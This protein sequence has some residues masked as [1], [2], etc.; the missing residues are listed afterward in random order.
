[1]PGTAGKTSLNKLFILFLFIYSFLFIHSSAFSAEAT[2]SRKR[3]HDHWEIIFVGENRI[4]YSNTTID[5]LALNHSIQ[6]E[7]SRK[8]YL[9]IKRFGQ[10]LQMTSVLRTTESETGDLFQFEYEIKNPPAKPSSVVGVIKGNQLVLTSTV[11]GQKSEKKKFWQIGTKSPIYQEYLLKKRTLKPETSLHFKAFIPEYNKVTDINISAGVHRR[12]TLL[13]KEKR[14]LLVLR[15]TQSI[16]P[17][18]PMRAYMDEKGNILKS[19]MDFLGKK[20]I[21]YNVPKEVALQAISGEELDL[22]VG[23]LVRVHRINKAHK[24]KKVVYEITSKGCEPADLLVNDET[25][26]VKKTEKGKAL[27]TV[28]QIKLN[29]IRR[30]AKVGKEYLKPSSFIQTKDARIVQ[31]AHQ[32]VGSSVDPLRVAYQLEKLVH[33][34]VSEKN[35]STAL[36]SAAEVAQSLQGDCTEH[37]VLLAALLRVKRIPSRIVVGMVYTARQQAFGG[38][39]WTEA[40]IGNQWVPLDA[41]MGQGGIGAAH[42][43]MGTSSFSDDGPSPITAFLPLHQILGNMEINILSSE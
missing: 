15:I 16:L 9:K 29:P 11:N 20:M 34:K 5:R 38:H 14:K 2:L 43:K 26:E 4:G 36:A 10:D 3:L 22:A 32:V 24:T 23:T 1:M 35:F 37:A 39:M 7:T 8:T 31:L 30:N 25:Q 27:V 17:T 40:L 28:T 21:T 13:N 19:E 42:I 6:L 33:K 41:T 18:M 12:T